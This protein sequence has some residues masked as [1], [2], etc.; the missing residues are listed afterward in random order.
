MVV[1]THEEKLY[2]RSLFAISSFTS[3]HIHDI[4]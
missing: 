4:T 1:E 2:S 3:L